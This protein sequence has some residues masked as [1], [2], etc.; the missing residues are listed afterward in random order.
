ML[1]I[2]YY[3]VK[4]KG[5]MRGIN[6]SYIGLLMAVNVPMT[7]GIRYGLKER[8]PSLSGWIEIERA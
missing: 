4:G 7:Y 3:D 5:L 2:N 1:F 6:R 8:G